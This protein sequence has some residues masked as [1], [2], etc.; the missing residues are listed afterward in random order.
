MLTLNDPV[1]LKMDL[2]AGDLAGFMK[3][4]QLFRDHKVNT[5]FILAQVIITS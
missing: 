2:A 4:T 1:H 5:F 3:N